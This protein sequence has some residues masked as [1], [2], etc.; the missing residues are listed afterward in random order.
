MTGIRLFLGAICLGCAAHAQQTPPPSVVAVPATTMELTRTATFNGRLDADRTVALVA[1]VGGML[2]EIGFEPGELVAEGQV[3]FRIEKDLFQTA[4]KEAEGA[5]RTAEAARDRARLE[6]DRQAELVA[7]NAAAQAILDTAEADLASREGDVIRLSAAL[8]RARLNLSYTE[9]AA[10]F[11]GRIGPPEVD[12]G[13]M[14]AAGAGPLAV[15]I[16]LDPMHAEFQVPTAV[17]RSY[18]ERVAAGAA[19]DIDAVT[20]TLANGTVYDRPGD[21][22]FVDS[23][24]TG[25]TDS[26]TLRARFDNPEGLLLDGELVRVQLTAQQPAPELAVPQQAVQ[27]D[28]QGAFVL[29]V[30][31]GDRAEL[32]RVT[33]GRTAR[34][35][36]VIADGLAEGE[37]VITEGLNKVRPGQPVDAAAPVDG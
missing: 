12:A 19:S 27:R 36:A 7:R 15:L 37:R 18:L 10:P 33:V 28:V 4:V 8:D 35:F 13:A 25:G 21:V 14:I 31:D 24:V 26:V 32:R 2:E 34:G 30:G 11:A 1:R 9:I 5:L 22:D 3:L 20:L 6:R 16:R 23:A 29:V 17:L